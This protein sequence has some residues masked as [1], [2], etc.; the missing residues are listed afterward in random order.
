MA[1]NIFIPISDNLKNPLVGSKVQLR[2]FYVPLFSNGT[3]GSVGSQGAPSV[4]YTD[5]NGF[6]TF[7]NVIPGLY[8]VSYSP[9]NANNPSLNGNFQNFENT[10]AWFNIPET[11][12]STVNAWNY[13]TT[14]TTNTGYS[15]SLAY[16]QNAA[17]NLFALQVPNSA[18]WVQHAISASYAPSSGGGTTLG[19]GSTYPITASWSNNVVSASYAITSSWCNNARQINS[20]IAD[21]TVSDNQLLFSNSD[22]DNL[23]IDGGFFYSDANSNDTFSIYQGNIILNS[24]L[25]S[26]NGVSISGSNITGN[27]IGSASYA[28]SASYSNTASF[29]STIPA[30]VSLNTLTASSALISS[31]GINTPLSIIENT[32]NYVEVNVNNTN[33]G[34][35]ASSDFVATND[36]G[37][38]TTNYIDVGINGGQYTASFIGNKNDG[39]MYV[40]SSGHLFIG[41]AGANG[42][43]YLFAGGTTNTS[44][45]VLTSTG[46]VGI[47]KNNP[48]NSLDVVGNISCSTITAS[49][50]SGT[51]SVAISASYAPS[52]GTTIATG[53]TYPITSSWATNV[54]SASYFSGSKAIIGQL[55]ASNFQVL[56]NEQNSGSLTVSG[57]TTLKGGLTLNNGSTMTIVSP[58]TMTVGGYSQL[59]NGAIYTDGVGNLTVNLLTGTGLSITGAATLDG[60]NITTDGSGN[61]TAVSFVGSLTGTAKTASYARTASIA[62]SSSVVSTANNTTYYLDLS[63]QSSGS[64]AKFVNTSLTY[65]PALTTLTVP[66]IIA[67]T[68]LSAS[69]TIV[70][71]I[72]ASGNISSSGNV[73]AQNIGYVVGNYGA[74]TPFNSASTYYFGNMTDNGRTAFDPGYAILINQAG[75]IK[76]VYYNF[77][78]SNVDTGTHFLTCSMYVSSSNISSSL[79]GC[80]LTSSAVVGTTGLS[81]SVAQGDSIM[82]KVQTPPTW[83]SAPTNVYA[84]FSV[85]ISIP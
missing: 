62:N 85:W 13:Q 10:V 32:N 36:S 77:K 20:G 63:P 6:A 34:Y 51:A 8:K 56:S 84:G 50:L 4:T 5:I 21:I 42:N 22:G 49:L 28:T 79:N 69:N 7:N 80:V 27:L 15:S 24:D 66:T 53:S 45:F 17:N 71:T 58:G 76:N 39:Y 67:S 78:T 31:S 3:S 60:G 26:L 14:N 72:T 52:T 43:T 23:N 25:I 70:N 74:V 1:T 33:S 55:T 38:A 64:Q 18:S 47:G 59:D 16:T 83:G 82:W 81:M 61:M 41:N 68:T 54:I 57:Q 44:S 73:I 35:N 12:G 48:I 2:A 75:T 29:A 65:N 19:T 11:S 46:K 9:A 30:N 37:S 40:T